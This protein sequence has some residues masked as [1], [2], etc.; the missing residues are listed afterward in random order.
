V[1][2]LTQRHWPHPADSPD[3][4]TTLRIVTNYSIPLARIARAQHHVGELQRALKA[5][6]DSRPFRIEADYTDHGTV[7]ERADNPAPVPGDLSLIVSDAV[8]QTRA[9]LDNLVGALR[10]GGPTGKTA[11]PVTLNAEDFEKAAEVSLKGV[12]GWAVEAIR[13]MQ[14]FAEEPWQ[15]HIGEQLRTLHDMARFDRH[16]APLL[17]SAL[18]QIDYVEGKTVQM[19]GDWRTWAEVEYEPGQVDRTHFKAE[20]KFADGPL[21][22]FEVIGGTQSL[23][24]T[25][26]ATIAQIRQL[27]WAR[28]AQG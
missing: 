8:H 18:V 9:A 21:A 12:P 1:V 24:R 25:A 22:G 11:F 13:R 27:E 28:Q 6:R 10:E 16:R 15:R 5:Y 17:H 26:E 3:T 4:R 7:I 2:V 23:V 14:P 20:V 19:R